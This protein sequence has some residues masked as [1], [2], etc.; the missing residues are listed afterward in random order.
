MLRRLSLW[1]APLGRGR[2]HIIRAMHHTLTSTAEA[3]PPQDNPGWM[4]RGAQLHAS[5][6]L[7][8][9]LIAFEKALAL[10]ADDVN[11][12][13]ACATLLSVLSRPVAS[14]KVLLSVE[15]LLLESADGA[16]NLAIAAE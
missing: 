5:G 6:Q 1:I 16:A 11:A 12:A 4:L 7:E 9:A 14:Y 10:Q 13:S 15:A 3:N 2:C 8:Q